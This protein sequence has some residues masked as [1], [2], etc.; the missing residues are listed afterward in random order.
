MEAVRQGRFGNRWFCW[1]LPRH[2]CFFPVNLLREITQDLGLKL[3]ESTCVSG[4]QVAFN[5]SLRYLYSDRES[6]PM[7]HR[8][9]LRVF[10]SRLGRA[11][12]SPV[13]FLVGALRQGMIVTHV[14]RKSLRLS[15]AS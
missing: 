10:S 11:V 14:A 15:Q 3:E 7:W 12:M 9:A 6:T 5:L 8:V 13:F 2:V 4:V 1:E